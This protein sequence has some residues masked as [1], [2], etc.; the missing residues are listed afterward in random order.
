MDELRTA[1]ETNSSYSSRVLSEG[2][3][4]QM[5]CSALAG[6]EWYLMAVMPYSILSD[7]VTSLA[8]TR[9]TTM[10]DNVVIDHGV[11]RIHAERFLHIAHRETCDKHL[12]LLIRA[13]ADG[14]TGLRRKYPRLQLSRPLHGGRRK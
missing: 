3:L 9:Q 7:A 5:F 12:A 2:S 6:T 4:Q 10:P 8:N 1:M 11:V 14:G 13:G